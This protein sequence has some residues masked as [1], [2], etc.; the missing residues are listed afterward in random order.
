MKLIGQSGF[1]PL[2]D[3]MACNAGLEKQIN[4]RRHSRLAEQLGRVVGVHDEDVTNQI[5]G[6]PFG[7]NRSRLD[8][9]MRLLI[10][11]LSAKW[12]ASDDLGQLRAHE[13]L[14]HAHQAVQDSLQALIELG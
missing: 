2:S 9:Q 13:S 1:D 12:N 11:W 14:H 5:G 8:Q 4:S 6:E 10:R 7:V 3:L